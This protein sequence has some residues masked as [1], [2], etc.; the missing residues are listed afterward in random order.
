M[1]ENQVQLA[2]IVK[3]SNFVR[4]ARAGAR[5]WRVRPDGHFQGDQG[6][7][8]NIGNIRSVA[9]VDQP[10]R[11][12]QQQIDDARLT[13]LGC[14]G[15]H[16]RRCQARQALRRALADAGQAGDFG[17]QGIKNCR[18]H[19]SSSPHAAL[20]VIGRLTAPDLRFI[21]ANS[22]SDPSSLIGLKMAQTP[23]LDNRRKKLLYRAAHRG[24]KEMDLI[25]G[26]FA[27]RHLAKMDNHQLDVFEQMLEAPDQ[28]FFRWITGAELPP[29]QFDTPMLTQIRGFL[30]HRK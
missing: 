12:Q 8:L 1:K 3:D 22:G 6:A 27:A 24:I 29:A 26:G 19:R 15:W 21:P 14:T 30:P 25:L 9:P 2:G 11:P 4:A 16:W 10:V 7:G 5:R 28:E 17:K 18:S 20:S 23:L 13:S